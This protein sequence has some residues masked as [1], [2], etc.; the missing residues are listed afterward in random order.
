VNGT[1]IFAG[2]YYG[3][4]FL[5]GDNGENWMERNSGLTSTKVTS[6]AFKG[7]CLFAGTGGQGIFR[8]TNNGSSWTAVNAGIDNKVI[9]TFAVTESKIFTGTDEGVFFS[10]D[11]GDLWSPVSNG[12]PSAIV[13]SLAICGTNILAGTI[14]HGV[15]KR[16]LDEIFA[17]VGTNPELNGISIYPNPTTG[18]FTIETSNSSNKFI[19]I[20]D[21]GGRTLQ[22]FSSRSN[23][24]QIDIADYLTGPYLLKVR[25]DQDC[26]TI[27]ILKK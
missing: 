21:I 9:R 12:L 22:C 14:S 1:N 20:C 6:L 19:S 5:S 7:S 13:S 23:K 27:K 10:S 17:S 25:T 4:V 8:T 24:M 16:P 3:G 26:K 18:Q 2:A 15:W 11:N